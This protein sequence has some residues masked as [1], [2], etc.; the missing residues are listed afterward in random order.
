LR[1]PALLILLFSLLSLLT[2]CGSIR[3]ASLG[4]AAP[5][6]LEASNG[7]EKEGNWDYFR[8]GIPGNLK[9]MDGLLS[10][11]P[12]DMSL[13][14]PA[15]K[16]YSGYAFVIN[17]TLYLEDK[18]NDN[19]DSKHLEQA[20]INYGK[21]L[22]YGRHFLALEDLSLDEIA[23]RQKTKAGAVAYIDDHLSSNEITI[24]AA[25]YTGQAL[26]SLINLQK[27]DMLL[28]SYLP[29]AKALIDWACEQDANV[30]QGVCQLFYGS[31]EASRPRMLGGNPAKGKKIFKKFIKDNPHHWL[32]R[33]AYLEHYVIPMG[34]ENAYRL[35]KKE[36]NIFTDMHMKNLKESLREDKRPAFKNKRLRI[37]QATAIKRFEIM[38]KLEKEI[39]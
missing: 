13:L 29:V 5:M 16:G 4:V 33:V 22:S 35:E 3:R 30:G 14:V 39:F 27:G 24:E 17:E 12:D 28:V 18:Y 2:S 34:N 20:I 23:K 21:A 6:F 1:Y 37:Y 31:Y 36:L 26:A 19:D 15:I 38:K 25:A 10:I 9:L 7:F 8:D 11:R 32:G